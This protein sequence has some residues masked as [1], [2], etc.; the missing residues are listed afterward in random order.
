LKSILAPKGRVMGW[1]IEFSVLPRHMTKE[2]VSAASEARVNVASTFPLCA[3]AYSGQARIRAC[4][5]RVK[6]GGTPRRIPPAP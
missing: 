3:H 6:I 2:R 1:N 5:M 4:R